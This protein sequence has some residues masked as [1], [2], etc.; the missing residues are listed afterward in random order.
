MLYPI[1]KQHRTVAVDLAIGECRS[2]C[3]T[4]P[5]NSGIPEPSSI[6]LTLRII[7]LI[8]GKSVVA[9]SPPPQSQMSTLRRR[10]H[11]ECEEIND[12][13]GRRRVKIAEAD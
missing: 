12:A 1:A 13:G 2:V 10:R 8:S 3:L 6:G 5:E 9:K 7:S 4:A 11:S